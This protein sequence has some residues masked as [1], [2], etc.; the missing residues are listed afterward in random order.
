MPSACAKAGV[1][2][3]TKSLAAEWATY[4]IRL[5]AVAPGPFPTEGAW[6][7]LMPD[8]KMEEYY[9]SK[10][11]AGRYGD[12]EELANLAVFLMSD[13]APYITGECITIDGGEGLQA[14]QFNFLT[15]IVPRDKFK[16]G[17]KMMRPK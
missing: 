1:L 16:A 3:M 2:A 17:L 13:L 6:T 8:P 5:N 9:K 11:P 14:G 4:K 7:R 10:I 12:K 15:H